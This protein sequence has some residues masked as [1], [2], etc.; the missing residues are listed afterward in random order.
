MALISLAGIQV[1]FPTGSG[2]IRAADSVDI[3]L[4]AGDHLALI[5]ESGCGK[6]VLGMAVMRLLPENAEVRGTIQYGNLNLLAQSEHAMQRIRGREIAMIAQNSA[7][8]LNPVMTI[9]EQIA[10][11]LVIHKIL[12]RRAAQDEASRLL[13]MMGFDDPEQAKDRYP[14][15]FSGGMRERIHIAI[16]LACNPRMIIADEPTAG[17]DAQ[18]KLQ[19]MELLKKQMGDS[20]TLFL[21]THDLGAASFLCSRIAV[22][23]AGEIIE[24]GNLKDVISQPG[25]PYTQGLIASHPSAGLHPIPGMSPPP[26]QLPAGCRFCSRCP[27]AADAC[28]TTHP[29]LVHT[30]SSRQV[31]CLHYD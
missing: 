28:R 23:Y 11:P 16:A 5:G 12:S 21:I 22:M 3:S 13:G 9:G 2:R 31:R 1:V 17:L 10:E 29:S 30:G 26:G 24:T 8:T 7:S 14:H 19:V 15:E 20:Q 4:N 27:A 25:H 18:I 6:T